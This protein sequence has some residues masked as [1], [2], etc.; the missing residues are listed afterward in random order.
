MCVCEGIGPSVVLPFR[1]TEHV[2]EGVGQEVAILVG[3]V[4]LVHS[5]GTRLHLAED[6]GVILH[7]AAGVVVDGV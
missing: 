5:A 3:H 6:D 4:A 7:P 2:D 1:L